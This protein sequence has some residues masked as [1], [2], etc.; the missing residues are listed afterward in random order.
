MTATNPERWKQI[1]TLYHGVLESDGAGREALLQRADPEV[2]RA[3]EDLLVHTDSEDGPL[4]RPAWQIG[5]QPDPTDLELSPGQQLGPYVVEAEIGAGGMGRVYRA[6]DARLNRV[7]AIKVSTALF[8]GRFEHEAKAIAALNHPHICQIYD[9]GPNYLVM[10]YVDGAP[11]VV[12]GQPPMA[13]SRILQLAIQIASAIEAAH[14]RGIIH[15][16]LKPGNILVTPAGMAKLLDF[17]LAKRIPGKGLLGPAEHTLNAT[18]TGTVGTIMGT[19]AYM[20]PEQAEGGPIDA[21]S[22]IFS[23]GTILYEMLAGRRAFQGAS[24]ASVLG[25]VLHKDPDPIHAPPALTAIVQKCLAKSP[26][27]RFQSASDLLAALERS[28]THGGSALLDRLKAH[29]MAVTSACAI[30]LVVSVALGVYRKSHTPGSIDS[31]AVLPLEMESK[32]PE[33]TYIS[34]GISASI[35]NSLAQLPGLKVTPNSVA[36]HYKGKAADFQKIGDKLGVE[37]VLSGRVVQH[38]DTL[39][40]AIELDDVKSGKQIW[41]QQY[42][43]QTSDLLLVQRD[44]SKEVSQRLRSHLSADDQQKLVVGSTTNPEAYQLFLKGQHYTDKFTKDGFDKG[45]DYLNQAIALDPNYSRAYS[46]LAYNYINQDDWFMEPRKSAPKAREA[47]MKALSL[48]ETDAEAHVVL[49]IE[50][51]WYEWDW[52]AA[53]R[54]FKRAIE[55]AP[56]SGDAHGYYSWFLPSMGRN[57]E[58]IDEATLLVRL[59]PLSTG[60]NGNLGSVFVFTHQWDKAIEQLRSAIDLDRDYWFDYCFLGRAYEQEGRLPE[61]IKTFQQGLALEDNIELWSGLGHSYAIS[62]NRA[63]AQKVLDHLQEMST[64]RYIAPYNVAVIYAGLG[65]KDEAFAWLNRAYDARSYL[66]AV[67]LNTDPRLDALRSDARFTDLRRRIGLPAL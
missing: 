31:I 2:R 40:I 36:A 56:G 30:V 47:A 21:R 43:R 42:T 45:I 18:Q 65:K 3:V 66:L 53:E 39:S 11:I 64:H 41:G 4:D 35:N 61:A 67:Y 60:D 25:A 5:S 51:Q 7:V 55:I 48:N 1:E 10:E 44:I 32:D 54:E 57:R 20:S 27:D 19:P 38:G 29:K 34:D 6:N 63:E 14:S 8:T 46:A 17:G 22:D 62:G 23:F 50:S 33:A 37:T 16:D 52:V 12:A 9:V 26:D 15:R 49:A 24:A 58:A 59:N 13:L 28:S